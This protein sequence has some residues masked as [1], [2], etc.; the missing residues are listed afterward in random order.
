MSEAAIVLWLIAV[1][2]VTT[3]AWS[4]V[5]LSASKNPRI[6][7]S[8]LVK[9]RPFTRWWYSQMRLFVKV[10]MVTVII[11]AVIQ[12]IRNSYFLGGS[13][14]E[15]W[16]FVVGIQNILIF[17]VAALPATYLYAMGWGL[18]SIEEER[19]G[20]LDEQARAFLEL[21]RRGW[22]HVGEHQEGE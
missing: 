9:E 16:L 8:K 14:A 22:Q 18:K 10:E 1:L 19:Q 4:L 5:A 2:T 17:A 20:K 21:N 6:T 11:L 3:T 7:E 12:F 15:G 13:E